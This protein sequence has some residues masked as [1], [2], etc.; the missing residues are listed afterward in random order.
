MRQRGAKGAFL[1]ASDFFA[2]VEL[3][4]VEAAVV[5]LGRSRWEDE[6]VED[7]AGVAASFVFGDSSLDGW[8]RFSYFR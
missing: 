4:I 3:A 1:T 2:T 8:I 7:W 5:D 6:H